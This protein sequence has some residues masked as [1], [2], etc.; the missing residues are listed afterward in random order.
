MMSTLR[1]NT[2]TVLWILVFAFIGTIIFSWGMGGFKG[3]IEPG[4]V[5]KVNGVKI[6][7]DQYDQAIQ[8]Q[9][10][11]ERQQSDNQ[12]LSS[13]RSDQVRSEVWENMVNNILLEQAQR[14]A[15]ITV[16]DK[17]LATAVRQMPPQTIVQNQS[18]RDSLGNFNWNLY[19]QMLSDPNY[20]NLVIQIEQDVHRTLLQQKLLR[21]IAAFDITSIDEAKNAWEHEKSTVE[22]SYVLV[23]AR[24]MEVDSSEITEA[25]LRKLY[26]EKKDE[27]KTDASASITYVMMPDVPSRDDTTEARNLVERLISRIRNGENFA[28]LAKE[29]SEDISNSGQGGD[30]GWFGKGRMAKPFEEA[31][32]N[33]KPGEVVGPVLTQFGYHAIYI[34]GFHTRDGEREVHARHILI[35]IERSLE[36]LDDLR[37]RAEG[38]QEEAR[39]SGFVEAAKVYNLSIDT[40]KR[41]MRQ[42]IDPVL[43]SN[44]AA[45]EFLF[46]RPKG[47]ISPA[48]NVR[49]GIVVFRSL[50]I[51]KAGTRSFDDVRMILT[52][53]AKLNLQFEKARVIANEIYENAV[54]KGNLGPA[55]AES[56]Y[57]LI[58]PPREFTIN[59]FVSGVGRDFAFT[60]MA[61]TLEPGAFSKPVKG[62]RGY[63]IIL[64]KKKKMPA[65]A[66]WESAKDSYLKQLTDK[67]QQEIFAQWIKMKRDEAK[68]QDFRYLYYTQY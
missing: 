1:K 28:D 36:T 47:E 39:E 68:I 40:L 53:D 46:N 62:D 41:V 45:R 23:P 33:A 19:H 29:F 42:G 67:R 57:K 18:F 66:Q 49:N 17:E 16:T 26:E 31:A 9:F 13:T 32:F 15:G 60:A 48:Y 58:E 63:Y 6:T 51:K 34:E 20:V 55:L 59:S 38:F 14:E 5:G 56:A 11:S 27:F 21:R 30:L 44:R 52:R 25:Q 8:N 54:E 4:I 64:L 22:A 43:G 10:N 65:D 12:D 24:D 7:R 50:E 35:K 3:R 61:F 37:T 2:A